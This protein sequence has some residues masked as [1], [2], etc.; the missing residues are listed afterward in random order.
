VLH[1]TVQRLYS[2]QCTNSLDHADRGSSPIA[3]AFFCTRILAVFGRGQLAFRLIYVFGQSV[4]GASTWGC[5]SR[6]PT[7]LLALII[8]VAA[9]DSP[10]FWRV[11]GDS[12]SGVGISDRSSETK[13][14]FT[15]QVSSTTHTTR[16]HGKLQN[17]N[18]HS[19]I[20]KASFCVKFTKAKKHEKTGQKT[21][22]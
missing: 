2:V 12:T 1:Y 6:D 22:I 8:D 3:G 7:L 16:S 13:Q 21:S 20:Q 4:W 19:N 17:D 9:L 10:P 5:W 11:L 14:R 15:E 18:K